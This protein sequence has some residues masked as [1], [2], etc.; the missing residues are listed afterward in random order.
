ME[1]LTKKAA[2]FLFVF[3]VLSVAQRL[4]GIGSQPQLICQLRNTFQMNTSLKRNSSDTD[5]MTSSDESKPFRA[6]SMF[7]NMF[8]NLCRRGG[9]NNGGGGGG[10]PSGFKSLTSPIRSFFKPKSNKET[11]TQRSRQNSSSE[12]EV[13]QESPDN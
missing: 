13:C 5:T 12:S 4:T 9:S 3:V 2:I 10:G 1:S 6:L 7:E 11:E 8:R